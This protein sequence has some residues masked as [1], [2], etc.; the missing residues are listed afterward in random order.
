MERDISYG[1]LAKLEAAFQSQVTN[2]GIYFLDS[3][4]RDECLN[5]F[6]LQYQEGND[7]PRI[8]LLYP[9]RHVI[10]NQSELMEGFNAELEEP[11]NRFL[12][13]A[14]KRDGYIVNEENENEFKALCDEFRNMAFDK[15]FTVTK[16]LLIKRKKD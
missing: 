16:D 4:Y 7:K 14:L 13:D 2:R 10:C 11:L 8:R 3:D 1:E 12:Y 15:L 6:I 5:D 9:D